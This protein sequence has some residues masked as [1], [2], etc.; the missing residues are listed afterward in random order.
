V[1]VKIAELP[2]AQRRMLRILAAY[3]TMTMNDVRRVSD[4]SRHQVRPMESLV[5]KGLAE[6]HDADAPGVYVASPLRA[7][8]ITEAGRVLAES[9][10]L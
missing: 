9:G 4:V 3:G 1:G 7:W 5:H 10:A 6:A 2:M 8:R